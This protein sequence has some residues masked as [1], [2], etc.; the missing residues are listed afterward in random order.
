VGR[1]NAAKL[2]F[3]QLR[4]IQQELQEASGKIKIEPLLL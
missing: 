2:G 4:D 1:D 3:A